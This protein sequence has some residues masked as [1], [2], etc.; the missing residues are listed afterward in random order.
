MFHIVYTKDLA[1]LMSWLSATKAYCVLLIKVLS[2]VIIKAVHYTV[3]KGN[4]Y[5]FLHALLFSGKASILSFAKGVPKAYF[6]ATKA[7]IIK[8]KA[9]A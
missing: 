8:E 9:I 5:I 6:A 3:P 2:F 7:G 1:G 4:H